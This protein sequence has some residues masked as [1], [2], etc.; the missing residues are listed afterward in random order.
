MAVAEQ[1][2]H[3]ETAALILRQEELLLEKLHEMVN[4]RL[5][6]IVRRYMNSF[7][8]DNVIYDA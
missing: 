8:G 2:E 1:I 5:L 7:C 4:S 3:Q 6:L